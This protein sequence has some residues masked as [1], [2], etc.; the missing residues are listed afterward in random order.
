MNQAEKIASLILSSRRVAVLTGAGISTESGIPDFRG[1]GT[2]LWERYDPIDVLSLEALQ[3]RPDKFYTVGFKILT[4]AMGAQPNLSHEI[5][6]RMEKSSLIHAVIT[7]NIDG[8][9]QLAGSEHVLEVHGHLRTCHCM[10][11]RKRFPMP[12]IVD[13]IDKGDIPPQCICG[14]AIRPD[15]VLFGDP[16]TNVL[17]Q[18]IYESQHCDLLLVLGSSLSVAPVCNLPLMSRRFVIINRENTPCDRYADLV[19]QTNI[20]EALV[21]VEASL[22]QLSSQLS[23]NN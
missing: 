19:W 2:G 8:L 10:N 9:H 16:M 12:E 15:I 3:R 17:D 18:A 4:G 20:T 13:R 21:Q 22:N 11:C 7:Q 23:N 5:L 6:A 1:Q 14:G